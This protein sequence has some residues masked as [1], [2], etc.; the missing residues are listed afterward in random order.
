M[1]GVLWD[2]LF[3]HLS[4]HHTAGP[5]EGS[6]ACGHQCPPD[7]EPAR[8]AL[9]T[10]VTSPHAAW[11]APPTSP[12]RDVQVWLTLLLATLTSDLEEGWGWGDCPRSTWGQEV[13]GPLFQGFVRVLLSGVFPSGTAHWSDEELS[14]RVGGSGWD[15]M[16]GGAVAQA[17]VA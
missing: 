3:Q 9:D 2:A 15:G 8:W 11:P 4:P 1:G 16:G 7:E 5:R 14:P 6:W 12:F 13:D 17:P 10:G